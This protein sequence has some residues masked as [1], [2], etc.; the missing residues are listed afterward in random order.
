MLL[1]RN[2][3]K[4][5]LAKILEGGFFLRK[6]LLGRVGTGLNQLWF[7]SRGSSGRKMNG[8]LA[9]ARTQD[10]RLKRA[11]LYQLSYELVQ[12]RF[13]KTNTGRRFWSARTAAWRGCGRAGQWAAACNSGNRR[14]SR[15]KR[16]EGGRG[17]RDGEV[18]V[19][20]R[21]FFA[22]VPKYNRRSFDSA[23]GGLSTP[24]AAATTLRSG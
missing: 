14:A 7:H 19:M 4:R 6:K 8:E 17:W 5:G 15:S 20:S 16:C 18:R 11:L 10:P 13:F 2:Q 22:S 9:G 23:Q 1:G 21:E 12:G 3:S 24:V